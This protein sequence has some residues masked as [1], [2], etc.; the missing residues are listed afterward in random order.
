MYVPA[1]LWEDIYGSLDVQLN[2]EYGSEIRTCIAQA[3]EDTQKLMLAAGICF[4]II[5]LV[6]MFVVRD[7]KLDKK[8]VKGIVF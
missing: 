5:P 1:D 8:Q 2:Y 7:F 3:R 6:A 4:N